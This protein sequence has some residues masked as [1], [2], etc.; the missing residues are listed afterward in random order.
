MWWGGLDTNVQTITKYSS[1]WPWWGRSLP[2]GNQWECWDPGLG[3]NVVGLPV[4]LPP[5]ILPDTPR[6]PMPVPQYTSYTLGCHPHPLGAPMCL[7]A[8]IP[9][10]PQSTYTPISPN[11]P[12]TTPTPPDVPYSPQEPPMPPYA[13]YTP[14]GPWVPTLP[15]SPK[16]TLSTAIHPWLLHTSNSPLMSLHP[17]GV[18]KCPLCHLYPFWPMRTYTPC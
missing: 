6:S 14:S 13:T 3:P 2:K 9:V 7:Y 10:W 4:H 11:T 5:P 18:L 12:L 16:T 15:A 17:L 1:K 8:P